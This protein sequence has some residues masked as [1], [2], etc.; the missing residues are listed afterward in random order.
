MLLVLEFNGCGREDPKDI[1]VDTYFRVGKPTVEQ[2][3]AS[4]GGGQV[5]AGCRGLVGR[6]VRGR[7]CTQEGDDDGQLHGAQKVV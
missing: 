4:L 3:V 7:C 6:D 5:E 1:V 2:W